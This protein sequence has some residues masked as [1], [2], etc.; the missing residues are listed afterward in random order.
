MNKEF[1]VYKNSMNYISSKSLS[2]DVKLNYRH[3]KFAKRCN[4][5][6]IMINLN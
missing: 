5:L 1:Q 3:N 4:R 2:V 6:V